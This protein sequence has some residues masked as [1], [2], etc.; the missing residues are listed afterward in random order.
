[1]TV[2]QQKKLGRIWLRCLD[3]EQALSD[4]ER[5]AYCV[6]RI[7]DVLGIGAV[8]AEWFL[9]WSNQKSIEMFHEGNDINRRE[10]N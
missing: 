8:E 6:E 2:A 5:H 7:A 9:K 3:A 4:A 10:L 1:M